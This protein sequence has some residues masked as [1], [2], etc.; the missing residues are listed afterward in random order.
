MFRGNSFCISIALHCGFALNNFSLFIWKKGSHGCK[1]NLLVNMYVERRT[2]LVEALTLCWPYSQYYYYLSITITLP[3]RLWFVFLWICIICQIKLP[4][5]LFLKVI[6]IPATNG[7]I[8]KIDVILQH[9]MTH[10]K[11][12]LFSIRVT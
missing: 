9:N 4:C 7:N 11:W 6:D 10:Y 1:S 3:E 5:L 8:L 12:T 2:F